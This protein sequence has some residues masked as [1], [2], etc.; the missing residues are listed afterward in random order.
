MRIS[1]WNYSEA[2]T[3]S[4]VARPACIASAGGSDCKK[5]IRNVENVIRGF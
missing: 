4:K 5:N 2:H 3:A 1:A